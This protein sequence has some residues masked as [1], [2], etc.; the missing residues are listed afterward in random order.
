MNI[1]FTKQGARAMAL[2]WASLG[3]A[4][5]AAALVAWGSL[6]YLEKEKRDG[7]ASKR[8]LQEAQARV[9]AA[10]REREDLK[11]SSAIFEDLVKRGILHEES[12]LDFVER[13]DRLK[14]R[15]RLIGLE[16]EI[17]PQ[18]ALP[19]GGGRVFNAVDVLASR[20]RLRVLALHEGEA[21]AFLEDLASPEKGFNPISRCTMKRLDASSDASL[22][23]RA[24]AECALEWITLKDK[25]GNRAG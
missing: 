21:L 13:L 1:V 24:E 16:Y 8:E 25:R 17:A 19:L 6:A 7:L 11:A 2:A 12:R 14:S 5:I 9:E 10:R 20:V 23:P 4:I 22:A 15:H 3:A 18:R